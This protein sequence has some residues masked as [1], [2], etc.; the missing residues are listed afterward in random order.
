MKRYLDCNATC[1]PVQQ[2]L[3]ATARAAV[4]AVGNPSS[5]HWAG[6]AAR[7]IIDD[8]RDTLAAFVGCES[9]SVVFTSGG[10]EANNI[11]IHSVLS[12]VESGRVICT[13][14]EH[15]AVLQPLQ[16]ASDHGFEIVSVRPDAHG[17]VSAEAMIDA[18]TDDTRMVCMM[19]VNNESGAIQPVQQVADYCRD[20]GVPVLVDAVQALGKL[21]LDFKA[22]NVDFMSLSAH[23]IGGPKGVGALLVKRGVKL[24][25]L[26]PGG[27]QERKRRSGTENVPGIAGF[28]AALGQIDFSQFAPVRDAFEQQLADKIPEVRIVSKDAT[29]TANTS[30]FM[31][32]GM[33]GETLLMQLDL[34]G[35]AVASGSACSSGKREASHV[36]LAMG[37]NDTAARSSV[38]VSFGPGN[39]MDD[40][41]ALVHALVTVRQRLRAMAGIR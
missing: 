24:Q 15:P 41:E 18:I 40:A 27:G 33:D 2:A 31:L 38:R 39:S 14:I 6:R 20:R 23:K 8:A 29:R 37:L 1:P 3:E 19:L 16:R 32:P 35:F 21:T 22:V 5:L 17:V 13:A 25:E 28:S 12:G 36:L 26:S 4:E 7:R 9:G 34:A 11:A 10:T 30:L